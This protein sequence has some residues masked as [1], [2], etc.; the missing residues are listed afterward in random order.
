MSEPGMRG[1]S[2]Y[3]VLGEYVYRASQRVLPRIY[4]A[5]MA[6][7]LSRLDE[8]RNPRIIY[9]TDL[10]MCTHKYHMRKVYAEATLS[11]EP[12][13][14]MG[15]MVHK[16]IEELL[17]EQGFLTEYE[18]SKS[19]ELGGE[20][21][22]VRGR[23]DAYRPDE[24]LVV[25]IKTMKSFGGSP[26]KHHLDQLNIYAN[27]LSA[28]EAVLLYVTHDRIIEYQVD[29]FPID[30]AGAVKALLEDSFHPRYEWECSYCPFR[31]LCPYHVPRQGSA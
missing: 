22:E 19:V 27:M 4:R 7:Q 28:R 21:Y 12:S 23:V 9:V 5:V 20:Y 29:V 2:G 1:A 10:T 13:A 11:F 30:L 17:K 6:E 16:G 26:L 24:G 15:D 14:V 18:V 3:E 31:K 25:E 8:S